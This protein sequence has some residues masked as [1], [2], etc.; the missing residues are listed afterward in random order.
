[1]DNEKKLSPWE[2]YKKNLGAT[3][4]WDIVNPNVDRASTEVAEERFSICQACP[5]LIKLTSQCKKCGCFM[6]AK[7]G[8]LAASCPIGKW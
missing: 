5:E 1:M 3:R 6:K 4:P 2:Q 7:T 8:L